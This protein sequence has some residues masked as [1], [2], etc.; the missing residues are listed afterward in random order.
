MKLRFPA[1]GLILAASLSLATAAANAYD[2]APS[3]PAALA[4]IEIIEEEGLL[5]RAAAIGEAVAEIGS[6][7]G[8]SAMPAFENGTAVDME[9]APGVPEGR[10]AGGLL[11]GSSLA[12]GV[13]AQ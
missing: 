3:S 5:D 4:T 11:M 7:I 9:A 6:A 10:R 1:C 13:E 12:R 8:L 2:S